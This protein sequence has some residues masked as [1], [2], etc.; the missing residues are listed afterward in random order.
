MVESRLISDLNIY[1]PIWLWVPYIEKCPRALGNRWI[2]W[3]RQTDTAVVN[4]Y[5]MIYMTSDD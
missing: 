2:D 5:D 3:V 1:F 4:E